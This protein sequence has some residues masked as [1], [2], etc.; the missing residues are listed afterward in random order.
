MMNVL[1]IRTT[2]RGLLRQPLFTWTAILLT[3]LTAG[4]AF[5]IVAL[6]RGVLFTPLPFTDSDRLVSVCERHER[7]GDWCAVATPTMAELADGSRVLAAAGAGRSWV[8]TVEAGGE[9]MTVQGGIAGPGFFEALGIEP[10]LGRLPSAEEMGD[11]EGRVVL[12]G[13]G[14]WTRRFGADPDV[15]GRVIGLG[16]DPHTIIGVLPPDVEVPDIPGAEM[17][18]PLHFGPEDVDRRDWRGFVGVARLADD[19][20]LSTAETE[21]R[22]VYRRLDE[23]F[24]AIDESWSLD[25]IP[26]LDR[27]VGG[28]RA[29]LWTFGAAV[30]LFVL[31]GAANVLNLFFFRGL[32]LH[33]Q[34]RIRHALG[35]SS[36]DTLGRRVLEGAL[37]G[38]GSAAVALASGSVLLSVLA[39]VAP[40]GI[41]RLDL[42]SVEPVSVL[43]GIA[44]AVGV[45]LLAAL[46]AARVIEWGAPLSATGMAGGRASSGP[47]VG[48]FRSGLVIAEAALALM[49]VASGAILVRSFRAYGEWD[50]GFRIEG[51]AAVQLFASTAEYPDRA[52]V[53][54]A[55]RRVEDFAANVPGVRS[56]ATVSAG[57]LFGGEETDVYRTDPTRTEALP[58][59]RWY[60]ASPGYFAALGRPL[61]AGRDLQATDALDADQVAVV[62]QTLARQAFG[63]EDPLGRSIEIP[64]SELSFRVVGVVADVQRLV[65]GE[66]PQPEL[67]WSNRQLPRWGSFLVVRLEPGTS[68]A[69]V[70]ETLGELEPSISV[71][72][73]RPLEERFQAELVRPR[74]LVF[75]IVVFASMATILAAGG[76]FAILSVSV[77]EHMRELGIRVA[78]GAHR[79]QIIVRTLG[80]G[81]AVA[82]VGAAL[83][84]GLHLAVEAVLVAFLPGVKPAGP[85]LLLAATAILLLAAVLAATP[86]AW[87]AGNADPL[88][89]LRQDG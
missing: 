39:R 88:E 83:G 42:V 8:F 12:L 84:V 18:R 43:S 10:V 20:D 68:V 49:L 74:F 80:R 66:V 25:L 56:A 67:F 44:I 34:D 75:L 14:L 2:A 22:A 71:G 47:W 46:V 60:D 38:A 45:S 64:E 54:E 50:P 89:L 28:V 78:L 87:K 62:N 61:V 81:L 24:E 21:L 59:L 86:P 70:E 48:R 32:R 82:A 29:E 40:P 33:D 69:G 65:P 15:L 52:S 3:G 53:L 4:S 17:W 27:V 9:P 7:L 36:R 30:L 58:S 35:A 85:L 76:L 51:L 26:L 79:R 57:P 55:W 73:L 72:S 5:A 19:V 41:P 63:E 1:S 13:H 37:V 16:G 11:E 77:T 31:I 6:L 23:R